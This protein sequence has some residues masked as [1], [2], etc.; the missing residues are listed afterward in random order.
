MEEHGTEGNGQEELEQGEGDLFRISTT[1]KEKYQTLLAA[2]QADWKRGAVG[3]LKCR[4]CHGMGFRDW[5]RFMR[6]CDMTK[7]DPWSSP[8]CARRGD[9]FARSDSLWRD[10]NNPPSVCIEVTPDETELKRRETNRVHEEFKEW[11][12]HC[13]E[14]GEDLGTPFSH[15]IKHMF[16]ESSKKRSR[17][18]C[19]LPAGKSKSRT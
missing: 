19:R 3:V 18:Q 12:K 6:H 4:L 16:P 15:I 17:E 2:T 11:E 1:P 13:P 5:E 9:F 10:R 14:T 7:A 8:F